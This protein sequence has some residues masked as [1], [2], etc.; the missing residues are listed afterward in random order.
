MFDN[1]NPYTFSILSSDEVMSNCKITALCNHKGGVTKTT[2][3]ANLGIRLAI[4]GKKVLLVD[5][6]PLADLTTA[7]G[8]YNLSLNSYIIALA[9][10]QRFCN[11]LS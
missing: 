2:T 1:K 8:C 10:K 3:T 6:D 7:L 4:Q 5:I 11:S 9:C